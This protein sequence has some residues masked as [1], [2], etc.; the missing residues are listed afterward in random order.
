MKGIF[1]VQYYSTLFESPP[2]FKFEAIFV[3]H[4]GAGDIA[5]V[6]MIQ[7]HHRHRPDVS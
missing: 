2:T 3:L 4:K 7:Y 5:M 6:F 1:F